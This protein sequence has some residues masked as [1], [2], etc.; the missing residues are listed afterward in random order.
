LPFLR[1][2]R[3]RENCRNG[4]GRGSL[5][6]RMG[7]TLRAIRQQRKLTL[8]EVEERSRIF[9][10]QRGDDSYRISI[11]W[12]DRLEREQHGFTANNLIV[13][14]H[15]YNVKP[16][17]LLGPDSLGS[18]EPPDETSL[19]SPESDPSPG[20]Y[21]RGFIGKHDRTLEPLVPAG[22]VVQI[23]TRKREISPRKQWAHPLQRP[24]YFL[25][26]RDAYFCGWCELDPLGE[27][28]TLAPHPLS[29]VSNRTWKYPEEVEI[30]GRVVAVRTRFTPAT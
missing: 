17:Q 23:D 19:L 14:A 24:L 9:A 15:I 29:P 8:Q 10:E 28:L 4:W 21:R 27:W 13:L 11:D 26:T 16:E 6:K 1:M 22:S 30:V 3:G 12:L 25:K 18:D 2:V 7:A 20:P 5:M